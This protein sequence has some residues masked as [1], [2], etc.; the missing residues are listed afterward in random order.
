MN[1]HALRAELPVLERKAYLNTGTFGPLPRRSAEALARWERRALEE[2]RAGREFFEE[3]GE[4]RTALRRR[5]GELV[6]APEGSVALT[7][8]TTEG[9]DIVIAGLGLG[10]DDEV[11]TTDVEHPGLLGAL[12]CSPARV[13]VAAVRDRAA[14]EALAAIRAEVTDRTRLIA[15]SHVAW[16]T[17]AVLPVVE[18]AEDGV[19]VLVDGA[20]SAGAI[21]V[22]V[23]ELG[24]DFFTVSGQKWLLG[25]DATGALFV[26][27][28]WVGRLPTTAPSYLSWED[29]TELVP[30]PD[31]RRFESSWAPPGSIAGLLAALDLA[32]DAGEERFE[33][34]V[35][36]TARCRE[37][38]SARVDVVT[39]PDQA[40]LVS[41]RPSR[42]AAEIVEEL[43]AAGV[44]VR[45]MPGLGWVRASCGFWTSEEELERLA[46]GV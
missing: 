13:R 32:A 18:L 43:A 1:L 38:L 35:E 14:A 2:G 33:R 3:A 12:R 37:R 26:R 41:F 27:A 4:L 21:P 19:P 24:C 36:V 46:A 28:D 10:A 34:A 44:V 23:E 30:W 15:L 40:T 6:G 7:S 31:A 8:S 9:C 17:G 20:Q 42:D 11:V 22:D 39:E 5:L 16:T 25:P 29:P 45:D